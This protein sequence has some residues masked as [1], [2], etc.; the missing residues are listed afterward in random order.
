MGTD[1]LRGRPFAELDDADHPGAVIVNEA[2]VRRYFGPADP[3]G[4]RLIVD[5][6]RSYWD[7]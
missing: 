7:E 1:I 6:P 5:T 4:K 3:L 2:F